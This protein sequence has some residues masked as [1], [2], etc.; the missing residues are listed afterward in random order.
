MSLHPDGKTLA[1]N[2]LLV[3]FAN[4]MSMSGETSGHGA[5]TVLAGGGEL[6]ALM[7]G[8][9]WSKTPRGPVQTWPQSLRIVVSMLLPSKAQIVL[10][11]GSEFT[12]FYNDAYRPVFG[13]KHPD[14]LGRPGRE[15]WHEIWDTMLHDLLAGVVRTGEAFW[16]Q[17][18]LFMLARH[19]FLEETYSDVSSDPVR[20][21]S[22]GVGGVYCIV[23]ETTDRV[24]GARRMALLRDLAARQTTAR[25]TRQAFDLAMEIFAAKPKDIAFALA[26]MDD[27][28]RSST[29]GAAAHLANTDPALVRE[30]PLFFSGLEGRAGR[31]VVGLNPQRPFNDEYRAFLE[32]VAG[33]LGTALT[34]ARAYE[35][36]RKR[37]E[38]LAEIDRAKTAF[39]S[40]VSHEFRTP[41]TLILGTV[42]EILAKGEG[43]VS[44]EN[45]A[46]LELVQ[47]NGHRLLKLVNTLLEFSRIEAGRTEAC[48]EP[49]DLAALTADLA[50][51]FRSACERAGLKLTVDCA[52]LAEPAHVDREMWEKIVLNLI[53]N[54]FKFTFEGG[55]TFQIRDA[56]N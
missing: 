25:T 18:L 23:T 7:R 34:S 1:S 36:E 41:L 16:A 24:V 40:N 11:W 44:P 33:Q 53:S 43:G 19:G 12:V 37:S 49:V 3:R 55:I 31:L 27:D 20:V 30:L 21:E 17:D 56:A 38:A 54:A 28:L 8:L 6:G 5:H 32:L 51:N 35:E 9:D 45:R 50:S 26:Y 4:G 47:R 14:A 13:A 2:G 52:A 10:F 46:L 22:A 48:Y 42:D 15:A 39:F 29:P